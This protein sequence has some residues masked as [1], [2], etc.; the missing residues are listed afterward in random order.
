M[1][2]ESKNGMMLVD[3]LAGMTSHDVVNFMRRR[4]KMR[5]IGHTGILDPNATGLLVMLIGRGTLFSSLLIG[6]PKR[7]LARFAFGAATDTYDVAGQIISEADPGSLTQMKFEKLLENYRG[8][9]EQNIPP[10]SAAKR[11]G[12]TMHKMARK[13]KT[14]NPGKKVVDIKEFTIEDFEWPE[15]GLAISCSSG[16]YVRS[17]ANQIGETL[18]CGGYL[19]SLRRVEVGPFSIEN[20]QT[21]EDISKS[22]DPEE[23][24][25]PLKEALP[26][27][28]RVRIKPQY[29]GAV[30]L[31][32]PFLKRYIGENSYSG[33]GGEVSLLLDAEEKVL[34]LAKLNM[35]WRSLE[36]L[37]PSEIMGTYMRV[38]DE[39]CKR[40]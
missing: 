6:M 15:V 4:L 30:L 11:D 10:F 37:S 1:S 7:Y 5:R 26:T 24:I 12:K 16:T 2:A 34:A 36:K 18:G 9:I 28:P 23:F 14:I 39:G 32:R 38:I 27:Y 33:D 40:A 13:G 21:L 35:L 8:K 31:G 3:K 20:A 25:L 17:L 22:E 19:K 29:C